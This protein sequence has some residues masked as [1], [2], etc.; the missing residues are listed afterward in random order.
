MKNKNEHIQIY[1][2][3]EGSRSNGQFMKAYGTS[4]IAAVAL[5]WQ[6]GAFDGGLEFHDIARGIYLPQFGEQF[7]R[8]SARKYAIG[9]ARKALYCR[10]T[11]SAFDPRH[12][13]A[14]RFL[15][16]YIT[17][18]DEIELDICSTA[19]HLATLTDY[20]KKLI[21]IHYDKLNGVK[22]PVKE[23]KA[24]KMLAAPKTMSITP[25]KT[26]PKKAAA[27]KTKVRMMDL[28]FVNPN[29]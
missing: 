7:C 6:D 23:V 24:K 20:E 16:C 17:Q 18:F 14:K 21:R 4:P 2:V 13:V 11:N 29:K 28:P 19:E 15:D 10:L 8:A 27:K 25:K 22:A 5:V 12:G 1:Y 26:V 3:K 9:R